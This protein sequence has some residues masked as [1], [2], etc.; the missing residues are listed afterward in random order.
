MAGLIPIGNLPA[1]TDVTT[2]ASI[3]K[4][5]SQSQGAVDERIQD[6]AADIIAS[7]PTIIDAA[8]A[9]VDTAVASLDVV[10]HADPGAPVVAANDDALMAFRGLNNG[11]TWVEIAADG[12]PTVFAAALIS[13]AIG[14]GS[15]SGTATLEL[16]VPELVGVSPTRSLYANSVS[17][18]ERVLVSADDPTSAYVSGGDIV[19]DVAGEWF[20][21]VGALGESVPLNAEQAILAVGDSLTAGEIWQAQTAT[22]LGI[23]VVTV[24]Q[25]GYT[26]TEASVRL[27]ATD[28]G[29]TVT[30]NQIPASGSVAVTAIDPPTSYRGAAATTFAFEWIGTLQGVPGTFIR[31]SES[32]PLTMEFVRTTAGSVVECPPGSLFHA[33]YADSHRS[34]I[35]TIWVGRNNI[36]AQADIVRDVQRSVDHMR[37]YINRY[38]VVSV[39][40]GQAEPFGSANYDTIMAINAKLLAEHGTNFVDV[41][42]HLID[43]GLTDAGITPTAGDLTAISEDRIPPSLMADSIHLN[44]QGQNSVGKKIAAVMTEKGWA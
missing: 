7:D 24:A 32:N 34:K 33:T 28:L 14:D 5:G 21:F 13:D 38:L 36:T 39:T 20:A 23:P 30:G 11:R 27:G 9:A 2:A 19:Y 10:E 40:N 43:Y 31:H 16:W 18:G 41:R 37:H 3:R 6:V 35:L 25:A 26:S 44:T 22:L 15:G 29:L 8:E 12:G 1:A 42:R 17:T 4:A